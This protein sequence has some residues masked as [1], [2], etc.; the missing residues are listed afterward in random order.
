MKKR[1]GTILLGAFLLGGIFLGFR[2][3]Q[4]SFQT[5]H[6]TNKSDFVLTLYASKSSEESID[7]NKSVSYFSTSTPGKFRVKKDDYVYTVSSKD[8]AYQPFVKA[9]TVDTK[10]VSLAIPSLAYTDKK[11]DELL[12]VEEPSIKAVI[13]AKYPAQ[14]SVY[15][16]GNGKLYKN[17]QWYGAKLVPNDPNTYDTLRIILKKDRGTWHIMTTP[18][19]IVISQPIYPNIPLDILT[20]LNNFR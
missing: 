19:E 5:V 9:V 12:V 2:S 3:Y 11:L 4:N 7:Y 8:G 14:L 15:S 16:V 18:P 10:P 1:V 20:D 13:Q 6:I 17:G